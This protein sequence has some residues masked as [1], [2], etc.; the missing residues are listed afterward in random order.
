MM[1]EIKVHTCR[2]CH[3]KDLTKN[4]INVFG[5][6]QY[7]CKTYGAY[8]VLEPRKRYTEEEKERTIKAYQERPSMREYARDQKHVWGLSINLECVVKKRLFMDSG[9]VGYFAQIHLLSKPAG[10]CITCYCC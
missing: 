6:Q 4:G 9:L 1:T 7:H 10:R 2:K 5:S 8:G 3:S